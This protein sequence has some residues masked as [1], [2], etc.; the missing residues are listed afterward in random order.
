MK[1]DVGN[2]KNKLNSSK[3]YTTTMKDNNKDNVYCYKKCNFKMI[4]LKICSTKGCFHKLYDVCQ[5]N[6]D[7]IQFRG[8]FKINF[9]STLAR[10][11]CIVNQMENISADDLILNDKTDSDKTDSDKTDSDKTDSDCGS[12]K[13]LDSVSGSERKTDFDS[14]CEKEEQTESNDHNLD[15]ECVKVNIELESNANNQEN[16][17]GKDITVNIELE[18]NAN[19]QENECGK[20]KIE[21]FSEKQLI[22]KE[23]ALVVGRYIQNQ[24]ADHYLENWNVVGIP[25]SSNK[26]KYLTKCWKQNHYL[27]VGKL[28]GIFEIHDNGFL[29]FN[30]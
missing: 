18:S 7:L 6:M 29:D 27:N 12:E 1:E 16:E 3:E 30:K 23:D 19:N 17:C 9:G 15:K 14:V 5:K 2:N 24:I 4:K 13:D 26:I 28:V 21:L 11:E 8:N 20:D 22:D 25:F 10:Y